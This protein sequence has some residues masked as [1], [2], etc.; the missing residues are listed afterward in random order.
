MSPIVV[1]VDSDSES[2]HSDSIVCVVDDDYPTPAVSEH[3][4]GKQGTW[5]L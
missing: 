1:L 3:A 2:D 5:L 4:H